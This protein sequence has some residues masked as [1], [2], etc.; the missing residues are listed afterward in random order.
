MQQ[1]TCEL[2]GK[3]CNGECLQKEEMSEQEKSRKTPQTIHKIE[4]FSDQIR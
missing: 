4:S 1:S 2:N 3:K